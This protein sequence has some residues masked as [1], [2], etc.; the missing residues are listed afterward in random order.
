MKNLSFTPALITNTLAPLTLDDDR[1]ECLSYY[2]PSVFQ[3]PAQQI[4]QGKQENPD[5]V[6]EVPVET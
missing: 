4:E 6:D 1:Q 5:D 3:V 2:L